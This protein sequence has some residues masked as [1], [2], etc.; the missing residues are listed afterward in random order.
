MSMRCFLAVD[1]PL[2]KTIYYYKD[3]LPTISEND[4][5]Y[6]DKIY[7]TENLTDEEKQAIGNIFQG[8]TVYAIHS[9]FQLNYA[10]SFKR[11]LSNQYAT[12]ALDEL[13]WLKTFAKKQLI[14]RDV[15]MILNLW[16]GKEIDYKRIKT[17]CIDLNCWEL[18][19][20]KSFE[21]S[22][23]KVYKFIDNSK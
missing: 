17:E 19:E 4:M 8:L 5:F 10:P 22:Y 16:L 21:F 18:T 1:K 9:G 20:E 14:K 15:F 11:E 13:K 23:G 12:N 7:F 2:S 6:H 3:I